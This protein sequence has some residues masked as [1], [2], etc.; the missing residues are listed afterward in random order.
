MSSLAGEWERCWFRFSPAWAATAKL[1]VQAHASYEK[2]SYQ[3]DPG[4]LLG[5]LPQR[6][7][8]LRA[9]GLTVSYAPDEKVKTQMSWQNESRDS[10]TAGGGYRASSVSAN[11]HIGF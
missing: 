8:K 10:S 3:G 9:A 7:D 1:A 4:F 2:R 5:A 11:V 6:E